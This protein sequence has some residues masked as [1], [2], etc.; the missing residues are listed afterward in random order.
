M[1]HKSPNKITVKI[2]FLFLSFCFI[3]L[4]FLLRIFYLDLYKPDFMVSTIIYKKDLALRGKIISKDNQL[5]ANNAKVYELAVFQNYINPN[6]FNLFINLLSIYTNTPK[7][8]FLHKFETAKTNR[9]ILLKNVPFKIQKNLKYLSDVLAI[10]K[11]FLENKKTHIIYGLD[12]YEKPSKRVYRLNDTLEPALGFTSYYRFKNGY[13]LIGKAGIER[14]YDEALQP[15]QNGIVKGYRDI[16]NR[17]IYDNKVIIRRKIDGDNVVLNVNSIFQRKIEKMLDIMKETLKAKEILTVVM[18][19]KTGKIIAIASSNRYN[20][21]HITDVKNLKISHIQY[22][23]EPGSVMKP[24]TL[25]ILLEHNKVNPLEVLNAHNGIWY[26][27]RHFT[28]YDDERFKWL[29]VTQGVIHSS[30]IVFAQLGLR[31]TPSEFRNG[32]LQFGFS[33]KSGIDLPYEY[34]GLLFSLRDFKSEVHRASMAF[35]YGLQVNLIQLLKAYNSF[36]NYGIM[37]TPKIAYKYRNNIIQITKKQVISPAVSATILRIL[38]K[39]VLYG[40]AKNAKV[41]GIFIAGKTG[42][43]KINKKGKYIEGLYN[44]SFIGFANDKTHKYTIATLTI[45]PDE[46]HYF[47]SQSS[48]VVFKNIV[49]IMLDMNMLKKMN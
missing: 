21:N 3:M 35:G 9:V 1:S 31:L 17:I 22:N 37:V 36:N 28:I 12:I 2:G 6:K 33:Q 30:N 25:S 18:E 45:Q 16:K 39:V 15:K 47:A 19:S 20:P 48:V 23:Y 34:K 43:A 42:T 49:N 10:K 46:K 24:I 5:L 38:R 13:R 7:S 32:L 8:Y 29:S 41:D 26:F 40:T 44:S 27:K 11:V 14:Y 4:L